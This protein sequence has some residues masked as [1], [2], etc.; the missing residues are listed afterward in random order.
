LGKILLNL[1]L[2]KNNLF[3][4]FSISLLKLLINLCK[5]Y[6]QEVEIIPCPKYCLCI[7]EVGMIPAFGMFVC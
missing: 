5:L 4:F 1:V 6:V 7:I 3:R 2:V